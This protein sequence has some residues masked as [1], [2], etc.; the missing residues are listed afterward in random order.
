M[1]EGK[2]PFNRFR[3]GMMKKS[4]IEWTDKTW[5]PVSGC[6]KV[7]AGCANCYAKQEVDSR[8]SRNPK[9]IFFGRN[10]SEVQTHESQLNVPLQWKKPRRIFVCPRGDPFHESVP[11]EFIDR[12]LAV[13]KLCPQHTFQILTKRAERMVAY[14]S[15]RIVPLNVWIGV[16]IEN[17]THGLLRINLLQTIEATVRFLLI[18]PLIEDIGNIVLTGIHWVICGGETGVLARPMHPDWV[19]GLRDQCVAAGVPFLF[20]QWGEWILAESGDGYAKVGIKRSGR[21]LDGKLYNEYPR[22]RYEKHELYPFQ[23]RRESLQQMIEYPEYGIVE[24]RRECFPANYTIDRGL[25]IDEHGKH[26]AHKHIS[27]TER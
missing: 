21:L 7:S 17:R 14:F 4:G 20:K 18:E 8:L 15:N 11:D 23:L 12:I 13:I 19:R 2:F 25:R 26:Y 24:C 3:V 5:S 6:T 22:L 27:M 9:S 10:F 16:S 1:A